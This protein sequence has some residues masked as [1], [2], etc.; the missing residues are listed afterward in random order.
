M[1]GGR[2]DVSGNLKITAFGRHWK[3]R[4]RESETGQL[5]G[6]RQ[7][8]SHLVNMAEQSGV[9]ILYDR[10]RPV[11]VGKTERGGLIHRL[12]EHRKGKKWER[13]D[14]F[15][16]YGI[17]PVNRET[18]K[19]E[20]FDYERNQID[21]IDVLESVLIEVLEPHLNN[22]SGSSIGEMYVQRQEKIKKI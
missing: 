3:F 21:V 7:A 2:I 8:S 6:L 19:L 5:L 13:W 20:G 4:K 14:T 1:A 12:R 11:Y 15:S 22:K 18:G 16:W 17:I 9:Y 10:G